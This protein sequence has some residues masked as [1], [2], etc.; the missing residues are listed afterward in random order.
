MIT[1]AQVE[2]AA[3]QCGMVMAKI[4]HLKYKAQIGK[5]IEQLGATQI[6]RSTLLVVQH[7]AE[8]SL[9][10]VRGFI[11]QQDGGEICLI[12]DLMKLE[13]VF[14]NVVKDAAQAQMKVRGETTI[15]QQPVPSILPFPPGTRVYA[16]VPEVPESSCAAPQTDENK[17]NL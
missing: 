8:E 10:K 9:A 3:D 2:K 13:A 5:Y 14:M 6:G 7:Q 12:M 16:Q 15:V 17:G 1:E 11:A 4:G